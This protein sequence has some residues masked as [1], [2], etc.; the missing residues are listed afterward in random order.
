MP[1]NT[2][3]DKSSNGS[4]VKPQAIIWA[5]IDS[6]LCHHMVSLDNKVLIKM[7]RHF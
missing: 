2:F 7:A 3:R 6:D 1:Q 5:N 4:A